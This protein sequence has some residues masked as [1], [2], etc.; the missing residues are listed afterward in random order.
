[1]QQTFA[2]LPGPAGLPVFFKCVDNT[3]D[4]QSVGFIDIPTTFDY[5]RGT[6]VFQG[7][8][9]DFDGVVVVEVIVDGNYVGQAQYGFPRPDVRDQYPQFVN[10]LNSGWRFSFDTTKL[11]NA[12]HRVVARVLDSRGN[13]NEIGSTDFYVYNLGP[14]PEGAES[15]LRRR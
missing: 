1:M 4:N 6:V 7:W 11:S 8:A 9:I 14:I 10:A 12:V 15:L 13:R 2:D 5:V 3:I